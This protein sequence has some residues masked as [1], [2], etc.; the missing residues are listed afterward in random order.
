MDR[1][2]SFRGGNSESCWAF[3]G[4]RTIHH[5]ADPVR[6]QALIG[7]LSV[8]PEGL[9]DISPGSQSASGIVCS[10]GVN[11]ISYK[12]SARSGA[13]ANVAGLKARAMFKEEAE[14]KPY[15]HH[16]GA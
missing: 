4:F 3:G 9:P 7:R 1:S 10:S 16:D 8:I 5:V 2:G 14:L 6:V 15:L 12:W 13:D 11:G